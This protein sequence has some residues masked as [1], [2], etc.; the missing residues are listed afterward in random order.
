MCQGLW[1]GYPNV[2]GSMVWISLVWQSP[3]SG[4][5]NVGRAQAL[6]HLKIKIITFIKFS[7]L[8]GLKCGSFNFVNKAAVDNFTLYLPLLVH[9]VS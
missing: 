3:S 2:S 7:P 9:V 6:V 8:T 4:S 5:S 1:C